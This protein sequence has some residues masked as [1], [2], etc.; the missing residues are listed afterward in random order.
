MCLVQTFGFTFVSLNCLT[1]QKKN[2]HEILPKLVE[3][4]KQMYVLPKLVD[5]IF[6]TSFDLWMSK[7][8]Q[9]I[10]VLI[11]NFLGSI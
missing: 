11:I 6:A 4:T 1:F 2:S 3:K 7:E 10:F 8:A 5:C 9:P